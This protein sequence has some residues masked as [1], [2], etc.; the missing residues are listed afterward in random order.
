MMVIQLFLLT[1]ISGVHPQTIKEIHR[2]AGEI[3]ALYCDLENGD[4]EILW[5][6]DN[7]QSVILYNNMSSAEQMQ[8][9]VVLHRESLVILNA[10]VN[11]QGKYACSVGNSSRWYWFSL[12]VHDHFRMYDD[13]RCYTPAACQLDCPSDIPAKNFSNCRTTWH[14]GPKYGYFESVKKEHSGNYTCTQSCPYR[15]QMYNVTFG[16]RLEVKQSD[17]RRTAE[18][19][20]PRETTFEVELGSP[21]VIDCEA[22]TSCSESDLY[23]ISS[24]GFVDKKRSS[25]I[26]Y[27]ETCDE[28]SKENKRTA[29]LF[30]TEVKEEDL[31][32]NYTCKLDHFGQRTGFVTITLTQ[33]ARPSHISLAVCTVVLTVLSAVM[34]F[35][36]VKFKVDI[37]LFLR[38][39]LGC[40]SSTS[41]GKSYDAFLMCYESDTDKG[42]NAHDRKMLE[43]V[44]EQRFGYSLCLYD[45][46]VLP[47]RAVAQVVLDCIEQSRTVVLVPAS[48][49]PGPGSGLLSAIHEALVERQTRLIFINT[50]T[51]E[52][53]KSGSLPKALQLLSESGN[54]VAWK[55][56][57]SMPPSSSFWKQL[58]YHLPA[59]QRAPKIQLLPQT[60]QD[61]NSKWKSQN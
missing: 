11:H 10:S 21:K 8:I 56:M 26:F 27:N 32:K 36:C 20:K 58:R 3:V 13:Q 28:S 12:T 22:L 54:H 14:K 53:W 52:V 51:P 42:F 19:L 18:I 33:K 55:G 30:F 9:G 44:L 35:V 40:H 4:A 50:E 49:D 2:Q 7:N 57:S 59:P 45:R 15:G 41:D 46:D 61:V 38:D 6:W 17:N 1:L 60:I 47:G 16:V 37:R 31:S 24:D 48:P 23:W 5:K 34:V 43:S 39:T 25:R 29:S